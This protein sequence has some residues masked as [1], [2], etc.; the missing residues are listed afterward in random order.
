MTEQPS[1]DPKEQAA[2][3]RQDAH[4]TL[5]LA[6]HYSRCARLHLEIGDDTGTIWDLQNFADAARRAIRAFQPIRDE[7]S[8]RAGR[9]DRQQPSEAA[10]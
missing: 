6:E 1:P 5:A 9:G 2:Q 7:M 8:R 4:E 10:E 3:A